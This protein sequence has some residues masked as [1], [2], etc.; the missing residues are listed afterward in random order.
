MHERAGLAGDT[1]SIGSDENGTLISA[2]LPARSAG[3]GSTARSDSKQ[4]AS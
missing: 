3:A 4:A 1:L 2:R